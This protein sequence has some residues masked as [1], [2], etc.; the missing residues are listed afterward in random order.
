MYCHPQLYDK[1]WSVTLAMRKT[2]VQVVVTVMAH[3]KTIR[4]HSKEHFTGKV[5]FVQ[6]SW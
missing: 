3:L 1:T 5:M 2:T 4:F 6:V